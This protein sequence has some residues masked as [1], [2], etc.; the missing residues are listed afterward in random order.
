MQDL[1]MHLSRL[2]ELG[3]HHISTM[4]SEGYT[5]TDDFINY[6]KIL[7][8][9]KRDCTLEEFPTHERIEVL[10]ILVALYENTRG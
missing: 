9:V 2:E 4:I 5:T 6:D 3:F 7:S 10:D 8:K 1:K